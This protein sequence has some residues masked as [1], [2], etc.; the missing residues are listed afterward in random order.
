MKKKNREEG[1][2]GQLPV[3][4]EGTWVRGAAREKG[5]GSA[6]RHVGQEKEGEGPAQAAALLRDRGGRQGAGDAGAS[7]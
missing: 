3:A 5:G 2:R 7:G 1:K 4:F 6:W